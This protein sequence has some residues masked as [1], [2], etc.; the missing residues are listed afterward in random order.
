MQKRPT[1]Y[2]IRRV[3]TRKWCLIQALKW[4]AATAIIYL[5]WRILG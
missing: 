1:I 4:L 2:G 3:Y 5:L